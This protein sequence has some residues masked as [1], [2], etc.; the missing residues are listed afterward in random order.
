MAENDFHNSPT[1][2][3]LR[4]VLSPDLVPLFFM[5]FQSGVGIRIRTGISVREFLCSDLGLSSEYVEKRIQTVF[6]DGK[7]VDN[8]DSA[9]V[10]N[11]STLALSAALPGLLGATLRR[12][13]YYAAMRSEISYRK[14]PES[15]SSGDGTVHLKLFNLLTGEIGP[16]ILNKGVLINGQELKEFFERH[17]DRLKAGCRQAFL[18]G[19]EIDMAASSQWDCGESSVF[20]QLQAG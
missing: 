14:D 8:V 3:S 4:M 10:R 19:R 16:I 5:F 1:F 2:Q 18:N 7:A 12:G 11:G 13:S 17:Y 15:Q 9:V 6:L 20:L